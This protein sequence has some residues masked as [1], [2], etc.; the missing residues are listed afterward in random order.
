MNK[1]VVTALVPGLHR[2]LHPGIR[3]QAAGY[4]FVG[5]GALRHVI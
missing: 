1:R 3:D 4:E 2:R 5:V